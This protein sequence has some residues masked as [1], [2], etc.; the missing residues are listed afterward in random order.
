MDHD[1]SEP[2]DTEIEA[3]WRKLQ[4]FN[5][6]WLSSS[7]KNPSSISHSTDPKLPDDDP[8]EAPVTLHEAEPIYSTKEDQDSFNE[9]YYNHLSAKHCVKDE[10]NAMTT[11]PLTATLVANGVSQQ[12]ICPAPSMEDML[13]VTDSKE[14]YTNSTPIVW[15][16]DLNIVIVLMITMINLLK[17][18]FLKPPFPLLLT[19]PALLP[20]SSPPSS[21]GQPGVCD[22]PACPAS[23]ISHMETQREAVTCLDT[24]WGLGKLDCKRKQN[25][26]SILNNNTECVVLKVM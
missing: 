6:V 13:S 7:S 14:M 9:W 19:P 21:P 26:S 5:K 8:T 25:W 12:S 23:G 24:S 20:T 16:V 2:I 18:S 4:I 15:Q 17:P 10:P 3:R 11:A 22:S 1:T